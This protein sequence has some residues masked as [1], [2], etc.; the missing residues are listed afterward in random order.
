VPIFCNP[1]YR[2]IRYCTLAACSLI[3]S[4]MAFICIPSCVSGTSLLCRT[5]N[6][7]S[8]LQCSHIVDCKPSFM[9]VQRTGRCRSH[10]LAELMPTSLNETLGPNHGGKA[11]LNPHLAIALPYAAPL[12]RALSFSACTLRVGRSGKSMDGRSTLW[13]TRQ[14]LSRDLGNSRAAKAP[15]A[16]HPRKLHTE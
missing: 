14:A 7:F 13:S 12:S 10:L 15:P 11:R 6:L 5:R 16:S 1:T 8:A 4:E 3:C 9:S 2:V